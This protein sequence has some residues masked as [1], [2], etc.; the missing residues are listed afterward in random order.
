MWSAWAL[1]WWITS[2]DVKATVRRE[3]ALSRW[4]H[5]GPMALAAWLL[6][7]PGAALPVLDARFLPQRVAPLA[8]GIGATL[9][10]GGL[11]FAVW[12][13][14]SLGRNWSATVTLKLEHELVTR[15][16]YAL[17][18]HP[19]YSGLL[20]AFG[21]SALALGEWR[22]VVGTA[23][24]FAALWRKL[25]LEERWMAE[26]FGAAYVAYRQRV[27]ALVPFVF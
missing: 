16:P 15:G 14:R 8:F 10:A 25:R 2:A 24:A 23:L 1:Y 18:R 27:K 6:L 7:A 12:A 19:I 13:R 9:T 4:A 11:L 5:L 20:L 17:V 3:P 26:R 22:G 21:G